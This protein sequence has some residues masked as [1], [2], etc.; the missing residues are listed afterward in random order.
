[1]RK[2]EANHVDIVSEVST[3]S[4]STQSEHALVDV[5]YQ[6]MCRAIAECVAIDEV[7][8]VRDKALALEVYARQAQNFDAERQALEIRVR[9]ERRAGELLRAMPK[10]KPPGSNQYKR[11]DRSNEMTEAHTLASHGITKNQSSQWQQLADVPEATFEAAIADRTEPLSSI[12]IIDQHRAATQRPPPAEPVE[13]VDPRAIRLWG[14]L[15]EAAGYLDAMDIDATM[16]V[17]PWY[18]RSDVFRFAAQLASIMQTIGDIH[19]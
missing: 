15:R 10:A 7:K 12:R 19:E 11:Q 17:M 16:A 3:S 6:S 13:R 1:V 4:R 9:A 14:T 5:R 8:N 2:Q 18:L